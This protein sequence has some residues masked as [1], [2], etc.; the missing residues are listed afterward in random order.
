VAGPPDPRSPGPGN[1][2]T[3]SEIPSGSP[4]IVVTTRSAKSMST[5]YVFELFDAGVVEWFDVG[6]AL[7]RAVV[8]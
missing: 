6:G 8:L 1:D 5:R 2:F 3:D 4:S 7:L